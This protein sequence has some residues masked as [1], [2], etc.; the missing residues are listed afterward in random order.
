M[1]PL[2]GSEPLHAPL[3]VHAVPL[4]ADHIRVVERPAITVVGL[5]L[6]EMDVGVIAAEPAW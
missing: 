2:L 3:A 4:V 5:R 6:I 1:V